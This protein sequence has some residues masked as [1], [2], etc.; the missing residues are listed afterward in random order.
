ML[1]YVFVLLNNIQTAYHGIVYI[2]H[3]M[4]QIYDIN[5]GSI[6]KKEINLSQVAHM[7]ISFMRS[8]TYYSNW[9][10]PIVEQI[11]ALI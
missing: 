4:K 3:M 11:W 1:K 5:L 10:M 8:N 6:V 9:H 7:Q 2:Y